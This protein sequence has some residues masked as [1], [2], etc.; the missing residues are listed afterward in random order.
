MRRSRK[1]VWAVSSIEGSNPSLSAKPDHFPRVSGENRA[2]E[3]PVRR[4]TRPSGRLSERHRKLL[5]SMVGR[6]GRATFLPNRTSSPSAALRPPMSEG[7][8]R[9]R[10]DLAKPRLNDWFK[11]PAAA[12]G[13]CVRHGRLRAYWR[14]EFHREHPGGG[15]SDGGQPQ[16]LPHRIDDR[17]EETGMPTA[18]VRRLAM[19]HV[20][21]AA[22][23]AL[24]D[25]SVGERLVAFSLAS[26]A[27]REHR[28]W[29]STPVAA[30]PWMV[31]AGEIAPRPL[32]IRRRYPVCRVG[33]GSGA[34]GWGRDRVRAWLAGDC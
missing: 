20:A 27:N 18:V 24:E 3:E 14:A 10:R 9:Q 22:A 16:P 23:L 4:R 7:R 11:C 32:L 31:G 30:A 33:G 15:V 2:A 1:P 19:S 21:I 26:F 5:R 34:G 25:V 29:P 12:D 13:R 8:H 6:P 28:A 17:F